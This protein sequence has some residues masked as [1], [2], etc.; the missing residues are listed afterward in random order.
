[1]TRGVVV[2][3]GRRRLRVTA[4]ALV[5]ASCAGA[6]GGPLVAADPTRAEL[7][8]KLATA[9]GRER[10]DLLNA[11]AKS[12]WGV[13]SEKALDWATRAEA[14]AREI[15]YE[16]GEAVAL[17]Y[18]GIG[19]WYRDEYDRALED[20]QRAER[21][22]ERL[23]DAS[24]VAATRSTIGTIYLNLER[25]DEARATYEGA[26]AIAEKV[27]DE[28]R[29]ALVVQNLGT[30]S[31]GQKRVEEALANFERALPIL[32]RKGSQLDVLTCLANVAGALRRL[33]RLAEALRFEE[34]IVTLATAAQSHMRL[35]DALSDIGEIETALGHHERAAEFL[36][37]AAALAES[38]NLRRNLQD[39]LAARVRLEK[40]RGDWRAALQHQERYAAVRDAVYTAD[41][42][43]KIAELQVRF[44]TETKEREIQIQRL[45]IDKQRNTRNALLGISVLGI[46]L[47]VV[48]HGRYRAK[49]RAA[50][51]L[52]KLSRTD[53]L[54]GLANRRAL[55]QSLERERERAERQ[56]TPFSVVLI[57]VDHF[58]LF[59]DRHGHDVGDHV[60]VA[61]AAALRGGAR[62]LDEV[63]RWGGEEFLVLLPECASAGAAELAA[64]LQER[65]RALEVP[66]DDPQAGPLRVT[67][68]LGVAT[69]LAGED[70]E[71]VV[72]RA[73]AALYRGKEAGRNRFV[74]D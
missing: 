7:E 29:V 53:P 36:D 58:K 31:L 9:A 72:R 68:T 30:V 42:A 67:A 50:E 34:R 18:Q 40:A 28:Y 21:L 55:L 64:R 54:T 69:R 16:A 49:R 70:A 51:L 66:S 1:M 45:V 73:D 26:L 56:G 59:N 63:A 15:G 43:E 6:S 12:Q 48:S 35:C 32:E 71:T 24:G 33:E 4:L 44:D 25:F 11:L 61:V 62:A 39:V 22:F 5:M 2:R 41:S 52:D 14:A 38:Q 60:L 8:A 74:V 10:V 3:T 17:R 46:A 23:G 65:I 57:D 13:S 37:R 19:H 27:G 47:A 20:S